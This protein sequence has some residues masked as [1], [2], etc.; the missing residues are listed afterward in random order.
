MGDF[1]NAIEGVLNNPEMMQKIMSMADAL[2]GGGTGQN[3]GETTQAPP[4]LS[5]FAGI[6]SMLSQASIDADQQNLLKAL[7]PYMS[8]SRIGRLRRAMQAARLA[9]LANSM[10]SSSRGQEGDGGV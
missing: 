8:P 7:S 6:S 3:S 10:L 9:E 1:E 2:G 5:G 4:D